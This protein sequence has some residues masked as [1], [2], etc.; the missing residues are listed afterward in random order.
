M[1]SSMEQSE[2]VGR[3]R[4]RTFRFFGHEPRT[5]EAAE[6]GSPENVG[7]S[8][9]R[10]GP[11]RVKTQLRDWGARENYHLIGKIA[12][13]VFPEKWCP[14]P[15]FSTNLGRIAPPSSAWWIRTTFLRSPPSMVG[16]LDRQSTPA[17]HAPRSPRNRRAPLRSFWR[18]LP[19]SPGFWRIL[20]EFPRIRRSSPRRR[21]TASQSVVLRGG[22]DQGSGA[23][24][25]GKLPGIC[26]K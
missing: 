20:S 18:I 5:V 2:L 4:G 25:R 21:P 9:I 17:E 14:T 24:F 3:L 23:Q 26:G 22:Y 6:S 11:K 16:S 19:N 10:H 8:S 1:T 12:T 13:Y 7:N 15:E